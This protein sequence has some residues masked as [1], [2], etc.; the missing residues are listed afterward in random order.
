MVHFRLPITFGNPAPGGNVLYICCAQSIVLQC[1]SFVLQCP[2]KTSLDY[3][4]RNE[5]WIF[6]ISLLKRFLLPPSMAHGQESTQLSFA[7]VT[8]Y[9]LLYRI[10][11]DFLF[12]MM[13]V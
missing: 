4:G 11:R 6:L 8:L 1:P 3:Q 13:L 12:R 7:H 9:S 10:K 5:L 2:S